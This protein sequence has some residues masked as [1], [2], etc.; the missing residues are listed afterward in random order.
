MHPSVPMAVLAAILLHA[1]PGA[2]QEASSPLPPPVPHAVATPPDT[3]VAPAAP[4]PPAAI[5]EPGT[6]TDSVV[7]S[8]V[9][10]GRPSD[11]APPSDS[12]PRAVSAPVPPTVSPFVWLV[13]RSSAPQG[14]RV[15]VDDVDAVMDS[16][17]RWQAEVP[18]DSFRRAVGSYEICLF[19]GGSRLC[20]SLRPQGFDTLEIAPLKIVV[21]S[22]VETRDTVRTIYDTSSVDSAALAMA[23]SGT[24]LKNSQAGRSVTIRAKRRPP[25]ILGQE[26]VTIQTIKRLP[27]LAEPDVMRAVQALPGVVSS[28]DFSTK[29]YVRGSASDQNLILYDN[30]VVYSPAHFGGLFSTFLADVTGGLDFYKGGFDP[31]YGNRLA[32]VLLVSSKVGGS[33]APDSL[34]WVETKLNRLT[35]TIPCKTDSVKSAAVASALP[36]SSREKI[37]TLRTHT[38]MRLTTFS[39]TVAND[40]RKGNWSWAVGSRRTWIGTALEVARDIGATD[41]ALDYDFYDNQA[42]VAWGNRGDSVRVSVYQGQDVLNFKPL[43]LEW[44]NVVL[45]VNVRK[46]LG[47]N[48]YF[49]GSGAYSQFHQRFKFSDIFNIY[50]SVETWNGRAGLVWDPVASHR[51]DGGYEY[52]TFHV[53]FKEEVPIQA[54]SFREGPTEDLHAGW[55][56]DRWI[57]NPQHSVTAGVRAQW[58]PEL[59]E[60]SFDPRLSYTWKFDKNWKFDAHW[61]HYTQYLTSLNLDG[62]E[63]INEYWYPTREPMK[64]TTQDMLALGVE[65]S[66]LTPLG[67]RAGVEAY[68]KD[69]RDI[70]FYFPNQT[71]KEYESQEKSGRDYF[72]SSFAALDGWSAGAEWTLNKED[73]WW[74][75]GLSYA[76]SWAVLQQQPYHNAIQDTTFDP[77]WADWDQRNT[78]KANGALNWLGPS[79]DD[80]LLR[81]RSSVPL[82]VKI[83]TTCAFPPIAFLWW[84]AKADYLRSSFQVNYSTGLPLTD[85]S[86]YYRQHEPGMGVD[87]E[88]GGE[89]IYQSGRTFT[90]RGS[91][92]DAR[93][94]D[95]FRMDVTPFDFG[96][97]NRWRVYWTLINVTDRANLFMV[98]YDTSENP[99]KR[100]ETTQFPFLPI[101]VGWEYEF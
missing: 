82:W 100:D 67:L 75:G 81:D 61:G 44:G 76:L 18:T 24:V 8:P 11:S 51:L 14:S 49:Q 56:Q 32:S 3:S 20:T 42:S 95:Y 1:L 27:G 10:A 70:P 40:G 52:N 45:P 53:L 15:T 69:L 98:N 12:T 74:T 22:V 35:G 73:G 57:I 68:Y 21:D 62:S 7:A 64:P 13:V 80:A 5:A 28:S 86:G 85:Y 101:F 83:G 93:K 94:T 97:T 72:S 38:A 36:D 19:A 50:N 71:N 92:N 16:T 9:D 34:S 60:M 65:R 26:R 88:G 59:E 77:Y 84:M 39:G 31:K 4:P 89:M 17:G 46:K 91:R 6:P 33:T 99:P 79:K 30:A 87:G 47:D 55:L 2:A 58:Y 63:S 78:V 96:R 41:F 90:P 43:E 48:L 29:V 54:Y 25:R 37:D 66:N 23:S